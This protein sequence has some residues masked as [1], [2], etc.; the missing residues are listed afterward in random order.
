MYNTHHSNKTTFQCLGYKKTSLSPWFLI[1]SERTSVASLHSPFHRTMVFSPQKRVK[2]FK[3]D[4]L[5]NFELFEKHLYLLSSVQFVSVSCVH[6]ELE[7]NCTT[8]EHCSE[9]P[10]R[11]SPYETSFL[12][13]FRELW[14]VVNIQSNAKIIL[15][16]LKNHRMLTFSLDM[17]Q[18]L[19]SAI[20]KSLFIR[21]NSD[22][23]IR[24]NLLENYVHLQWIIIICL[25]KFVKTCVEFTI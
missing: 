24:I 25:W 10:Q 4:W 11:S 8:V 1:F 5:S 13:V 23:K 18:M 2:H 15:K 21:S 9:K 22:P 12:F 14:L 19:H 16:K 3:K 20:Q 6:S 17:M 7:N